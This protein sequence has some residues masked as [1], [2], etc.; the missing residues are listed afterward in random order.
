MTSQRRVHSIGPY[1]V[2][3]P[4][5][6]R[7]ARVL[8]SKHHLLRWFIHCTRLN[9]SVFSVGW[10]LILWVFVPACSRPNATDDT[11]PRFAFVVNVPADRYWDIAYAG[12]LQAAS[13]ENVTVEFHAPNEATAQQQKQ[14][15]E[16]LMSRGL[17][18]LAITPLNPESLTAVLNQAAEMFPVICQDSDA[19]ESNR[20][21]YIG[22]DNVELGRQMGEMMKQALPAGGKVAIFVG[23]LDVANAKERQQGVFEA[24]EGSKLEVIGTFTDGGQPAEAKRVATDVL[25]KYVDLKGIIGLWGYNGPQAVNA[26]EGS[27]EREV[28]VVGS[29]E[30]VETMRG[31]RLGRQVGSVAQQPFE[32]GYQSIKLLAKL[33]RGETVNLP[34]NKIITI[35]TYTITS[36]NCDEV[37]QAIAA[38]LELLKEHLQR[39]EN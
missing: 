37:E 9:G 3:E 21:C 2:G 28:K 25:S 29:D 1:A 6:P 23:Q 35:D 7:A 36:E 34:E 11:K 39:Q 20:V 26:L 10:L 31:I 27:P 14:I 8:P 4:L 17:D 19:S 38:K 16:S 15:V 30:S 18:G 32:F 13:E 5:K 33:Q 22:T 24:I 12:C